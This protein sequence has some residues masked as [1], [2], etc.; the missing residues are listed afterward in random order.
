[1]DEREDTLVDVFETGGE[2][3]V[4]F[5]SFDTF[6][7]GCLRWWLGVRKLGYV[8]SIVIVVVE[9]SRMIVRFVLF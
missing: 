4:S 8:E 5:V 2:S 9:V 6:S 3:N 1:M 7:V